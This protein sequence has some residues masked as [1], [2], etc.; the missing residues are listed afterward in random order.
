MPTYLLI[1]SAYTALTAYIIYL[2]ICNMFKTKS[3]WDQVL[4]LLVLVP[5]ALRVVFIK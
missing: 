3:V 4:A 5:L 2:V 1:M